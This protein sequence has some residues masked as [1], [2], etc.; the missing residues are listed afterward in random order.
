MSPTQTRL[1]AVGANWPS[2]RLGAAHRAGSEF[3]VRGTNER[4]CY[5]RGCYERGCYER[6]PWAASVRRMLTGAA[7]RR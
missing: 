5:E 4:G 7:E 3:V 1:G 6:K 2:K